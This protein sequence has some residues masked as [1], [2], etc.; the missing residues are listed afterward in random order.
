ME[1]LRRA[2]E[3]E[4]H[5]SLTVDALEK[6]IKAYPNHPG[7]HHYFIHIIE[8]VDPDAAIATADALGPLMPAAGHLVH[9]PS[10]IYIGVGMYEKAAEVNRKAIKADEAYIAQ[11]QAQGIYPMVYYPHNIHFLW[12]A[13][14]MLGNSEEAIDAAEKV[15]LRVPREQ[16][17]QIHFIQ[18]FMSVPYQ[19]YVRFGKWNDMLSTPGP[20]I[21]L[22]H[23]RMMWHYGR[24]M[25]FARNG[26]LELADVELDHVKSIAK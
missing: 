11:C 17:S 15:A 18:D 24:G 16:A 1:L 6:V 14:S 5:D 9:M 8:A 10:H 19:A 25:A 22:M 26:L 20:D 2:L 3:A 7:A 12:A 23:T 21:S 13:A 4:T